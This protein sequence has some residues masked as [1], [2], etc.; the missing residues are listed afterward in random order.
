VARD[1]E[2]G[3]VAKLP[4]FGT[5]CRQFASERDYAKARAVQLEILRAYDLDFV[6]QRAGDTAPVEVKAGRNPKAQS[7][8]VY[9]QKFAPALA[10]RSSLSPPTSATPA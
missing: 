5:T 2:G 1:G 8:R 3:D 9:R 6:V 4:R 10:V 7:L